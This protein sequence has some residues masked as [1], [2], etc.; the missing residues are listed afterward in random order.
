MKGPFVT[1]GIDIWYDHSEPNLVYLHAV[2]HVPVYI[3]NIAQPYSD[4][5]IEVFLIDLGAEKKVAKH[6]RSLNHPL[7]R[8]PN[9]I[10]SIGPFD[11]LVTND[12]VNTHGHL[13]L[14]EDL[15]TFKWNSKTSIVRLNE[16]GAEVVADG[17]HN[18][19]G[20]GHGPNGTVILGDAAGGD[21][22]I[23]ELSPGK[24]I[25]K[26]YLALNINLDNPTYYSDPYASK[27]DASGYV[28]G[29]LLDGI[30]LDQTCRDP[31]AKIGSS[32]WIIRRDVAGKIQKKLLFEDD[33]SWV[34][35]AS[36]G[37]IIPIEPKDGKKEGWLVTTGPFSLQM[38]VAK[39]S[40]DGLW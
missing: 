32:V 30:H 35:G 6:L 5:R 19:N 16:D 31:S 28:I 36:V 8:T 21:L 13:R 10:Y 1:H 39:I 38:G 23:F 3:D 34:S 2:N 22:T 17:L 27:S 37:L 4:S 7:V 40:L 9:D 33:G 15:L 29:G 14:A 12:H 26:D 20:L 25:K 24:L 18:A 11:L